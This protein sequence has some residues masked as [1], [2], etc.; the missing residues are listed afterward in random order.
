MKI[1]PRRFLNLRG[2]LSAVPLFFLSFCFLFPAS[3]A[4]RALGL[5]I[6]RL[7]DIMGIEFFVIFS[8]FLVVFISAWR[9]ATLVWKAARYLGFLVVLLFFFWRAYDS[10][11][12]WGV[13]SFA[14]L[15]LV[16]YFRLM[17]HLFSGDYTGQVTSRWFVSS[18]TFFPC[19]CVGG[20]FTSFNPL[21]P[22]WVLPAGVMY[23]LL[24][25][26]FEW[27]GANEHLVHVFRGRP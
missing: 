22:G 12:L 8:M 23:F 20:A 6:R 16:T 5:D 14:A 10:A 2:F 15:T 7:D 27:Y 13:S 17:F 21:D 1:D 3:A 19:M 11:G 9:P 4:N 24:L 26:A 18:A 25:G